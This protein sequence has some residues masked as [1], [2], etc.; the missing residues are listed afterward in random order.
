MNNQE[1]TQE[2]F[3]KQLNNYNDENENQQ[4]ILATSIA[5][6]LIKANVQSSYSAGNATFRNDHL[7]VTHLQNLSTYTKQIMDALK[8]K[9]AEQ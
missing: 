5:L 4:R 2:S 7:L 3:S 9:T 1:I 8:G 6:E